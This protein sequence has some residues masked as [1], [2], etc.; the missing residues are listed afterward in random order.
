[1][2]DVVVMSAFWAATDTAVCWQVAADGGVVK[3]YGDAPEGIPLHWF[4]QYYCVMVVI[5]L[6]S[7]SLSLSLSL[8][9][10]KECLVMMLVA[11][12]LE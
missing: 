8:T 9:L 11:L 5:T 7:L 1:M 4:E 6:L 3:Q 2:D 12:C 10:M